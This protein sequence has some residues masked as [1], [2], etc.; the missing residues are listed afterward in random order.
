MTKGR[1][2]CCRPSETWKQSIQWRIVSTLSFSSHL[3]QRWL[4]VRH[5]SHT[6]HIL[7]VVSS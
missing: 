1:A 2:K 7:C 5:S 3:R 4:A 6:Q